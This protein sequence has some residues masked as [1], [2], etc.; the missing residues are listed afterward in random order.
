MYVRVLLIYLSLSA[1][2]TAKEELE[3]HWAE[4]VVD[5]LL[6]LLSQ[7]SRHI[8]QVCKTVFAS[9]CPHVTA[10]SLTI[11]LEVSVEPKGIRL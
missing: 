7:S 4:V 5:I 1:P 9:I 8:R 11:I 6:S 10:A 3:P 2:L